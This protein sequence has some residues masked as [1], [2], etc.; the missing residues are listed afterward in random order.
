MLE[1]MPAP[2]GAK[3]ELA[4]GVEGNID[5]LSPSGELSIVVMANIVEY[6]ADYVV[7]AQ[8]NVI[9]KEFV[10][11]VEV[12]MEGYSR[13]REYIAKF[14]EYATAAKTYGPHSWN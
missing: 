12:F 13:F 1:L 9:C 2:L 8:M 7:E 3:P 10:T 14:Q 11:D 4:E 5:G 6:E